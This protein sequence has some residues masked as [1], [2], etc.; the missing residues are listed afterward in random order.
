MFLVNWFTFFLYAI[1]MP[2]YKNKWEKYKSSPLSFSFMR[3]DYY[4]HQQP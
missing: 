3:K 4:H 1:T 2:K